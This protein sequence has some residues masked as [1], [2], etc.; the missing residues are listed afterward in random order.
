MRFDDRLDSRSI[1]I[2]TPLALVDAVDLANA[3]A[4]GPDRPAT[5]TYEFVWTATGPA[6]PVSFAEQGF[7]GEFR[8]AQATG[9]WTGVTESSSHYESA[10]ADTSTT[11]FAAI[12]RERNGM[13]YRG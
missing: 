13:F 11:V 7:E 8:P 12:G 9:V 4:G 1:T 6:A 10:P 3:L 5:V 2:P